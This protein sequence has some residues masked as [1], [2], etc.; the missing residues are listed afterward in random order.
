MALFFA[1]ALALLL[2]VKKE[3]MEAYVV[4]L[5]GGGYYACSLAVSVYL[6]Q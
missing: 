4:F 3:K 6:K 2:A 1:L 5:L